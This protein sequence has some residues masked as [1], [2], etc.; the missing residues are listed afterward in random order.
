MAEVAEAYLMVKHI[1]NQ[2]TL[3]HP[4]II[5]SDSLRSTISEPFK[6]DVEA[7]LSFPLDFST[8]DL[9]FRSEEED[10]FW[11]K[12][13]LTAYLILASI[14]YFSP[15]RWHAAVQASAAHLA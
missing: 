7:V 15:T 11:N 8:V 5:G 9:N 6:M 10:Q 4:S 1:V 3:N 14:W 12:F 2:H 13:L